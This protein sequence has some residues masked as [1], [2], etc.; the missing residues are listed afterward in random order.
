[1]STEL[2]TDTTNGSENTRSETAPESKI[3]PELASYL[4]RTGKTR[5]ESEGL[6]SLQS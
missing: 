4:N 6:A 3:D 1:M 5:S 2:M